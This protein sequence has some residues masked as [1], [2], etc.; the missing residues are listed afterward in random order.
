M[1]YPTIEYPNPLPIEAQD[2]INQQRQVVDSIMSGKINA[3]GEVTLTASTTTTQVDDLRATTDSI[4]LL[5]PRTA[6]AAAALATTY[7]SITTN[8]SF[9]LTHANNAQTDR[10]FRYAIIG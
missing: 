4:I 1:A 9:T 8:R 6:N 3:R 2:F 10:T 7:T 5:E